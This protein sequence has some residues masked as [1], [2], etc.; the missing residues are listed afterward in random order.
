MQMRNQNVSQFSPTIVAL[1]LRNCAKM[2]R[3][4]E[5]SKKMAI[6]S[7]MRLKNPSIFG[8]VMQAGTES[9]KSQKNNQV[10]PQ[11]RSPD[12]MKYSINGWELDNPSFNEFDNIN[13]GLK[14]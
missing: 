3:R 9:H 14:P 4:I 8:K 11:A 2:E 1:K 12:K 10:Q 13:I 5:L 6:D 7:K